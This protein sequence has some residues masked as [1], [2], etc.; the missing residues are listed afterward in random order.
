MSDCIHVV[1][2]GLWCY[3]DILTSDVFFFYIFWYEKQSIFIPTTLISYEFISGF[4]YAFPLHSIVYCV[5]HPFLSRAQYILRDFLQIWPLHK[6]LILK[7]F[8]NL[9][10]LSSYKISSDWSLYYINV[11]RLH[12]WEFQLRWCTEPHSCNLLW[13]CL[14]MLVLVV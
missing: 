14:I 9:I 1:L 5:S 12:G 8:L 4:L 11:N 6:V 13:V 2:K 3:W 7:I 10:E